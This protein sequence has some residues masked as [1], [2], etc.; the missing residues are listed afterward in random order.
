MM[1]IMRRHNILILGALVIFCFVFSIVDAS[2]LV[3]Q[4]P[5]YSKGDYWDYISE[6][7]Y[8]YLSNDTLIMLETEDVHIEV[9]DVN[10]SNDTIIL[11]ETIHSILYNSTGTML[12]SSIIINTYYLQEADLAIK[13]AIQETTGGNRS[14]IEYLIPFKYVEYPIKLGN[15]GTLITAFNN[16]DGSTQLE[17][18]YEVF[19]EEKDFPLEEV[20]GKKNVTFDCLVVE[21]NQTTI[22]VMTYMYFTPNVGNYV[23]L[24]EYSY[25][26]L[27]TDQ[28]PIVIKKAGYRELTGYSYAAS[29]KRGKE[30]PG[31]QMFFLILLLIIVSILI[32]MQ[33]HENN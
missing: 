27:G 33:K 26:N 20:N 1:R 7:E 31:L 14:V 11:E 13:K 21:V 12:D 30:T 18:K 28:N 22:G 23:Y 32:R 3:V 5:S 10:P 24:E 15:N 29:K 2:T 19:K 6:I 17:V 8:T 25:E 9:I 4:K 16:E